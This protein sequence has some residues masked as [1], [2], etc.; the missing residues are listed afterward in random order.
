M[1]LATHFLPARRAGADV[2]S[3]RDVELDI[4]DVK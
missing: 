2:D 3:Y 1:F 4:A